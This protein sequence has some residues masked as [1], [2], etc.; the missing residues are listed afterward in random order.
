MKNFTNTWPLAINVQTKLD[1][2]YNIGPIG[3]VLRQIY[4]MEIIKMFLP[5]L[6]TWNVP[7]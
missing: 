4:S 6:N 7:G 1:Y 2:L 5:N 3:S